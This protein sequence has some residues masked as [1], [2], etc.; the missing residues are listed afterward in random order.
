MNFIKITSR[1]EIDER[2]FSLLGAS[3]KRDDKTK[4]GFFGSGL[5]FSLAFMLRKEI[6]FRVFSGYSEILFTTSE[7]VFREKSFKRILVNGKETSLT[8]DTASDWSHWSII[9]EIF[10]NAIDE[11]ESSI[12]LVKNK[13]IEELKPIEDFT[14]FYIECT[15]DF[16]EIVDNWDLY[17]SENRKDIV[18]ENIKNDKLY[19]GGE[20]LLVYRKGIRCHFDEKTKSL[21]HYDLSKVEIN[22]SR[23]ISSEWSLKYGLVELFRKNDNSDV[24]H[25]IL[26]NINNYWEKYLNWDNASHVSFSDTW[27]S[28]IGD[29]YL[30]PYENAGFW[31]DDME[32]MKSN[33]IILPNSLI[34]ALKAQFG[35][36]IK[37]I[38]DDAVV[39]GKGDK[40]ILTEL[41]KREQHLL[42]EAIKFLDKGGYKIEFPIKVARFVRPEVLGLAESETIFISDKCFT[43]GKREIINTIIEENQHLKTGHADETR[44]M[45]TD[46]IN[47]FIGE[48]E[49]RLGIYL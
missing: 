24:I 17:F 9:R 6:K 16:Q 14:T 5:K 38:G 27:K 22:E 28:K 21:F 41:S 7:E 43:M 30:I 40:K 13:N 11:G 45:Q 39:K 19:S 8:T 1:G 10:S 29:N 48:M 4:I 12:K 26:Y 47:L 44:A 37:I 25:R 32:E 20:N 18:F 36:S 34:E 15:E 31:Q 35:E 23:T 46:L 2:A 49:E 33:Y 42:D 3:S